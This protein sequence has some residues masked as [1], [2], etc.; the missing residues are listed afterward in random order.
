[1]VGRKADRE[2][3]RQA[4]RQTD[5]DRQSKHCVHM[6]VAG[7]ECQRKCNKQPYVPQAPPQA[8]PPLEV[9][10]AP[11]SQSS[12]RRDTREDEAVL[13]HSDTVNSTIH[14]YILQVDEGLY[15][16]YH[17]SHAKLKAF[18]H[19][20]CIHTM[21]NSTTVRTVMYIGGGTFVHVFPCQD[22][23]RSK[24]SSI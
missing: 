4:D 9:E 10:A 23:H 3:G 5:T 14:I 7:Y 16:V 24:N 6:H 22:I 8:P 12:H 15:T 2:A 18:H 17:N 19:S 21:H 20:T 11:S 1:M 13:H